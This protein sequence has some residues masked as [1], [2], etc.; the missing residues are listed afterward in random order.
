MR[1]AVLG[2]STVNADAETHGAVSGCLPVLI[3]DGSARNLRSKKPGKPKRGERHVGRRPLPD[4][5]VDPDVRV[6]EERAAVRD[7]TRE[8]GAHLGAAARRHAAEPVMKCRPM[9]PKRFSR[10]CSNRPTQSEL[11][12][13]SLVPLVV[14]WAA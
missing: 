8:L 9:P 3:V 14:G 4:L 5:A 1:T 7:E 12:V 10:P 2:S 13:P 6:G 11:A